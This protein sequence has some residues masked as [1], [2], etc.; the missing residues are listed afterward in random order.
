MTRYDAVVVGS[1]PN[2][3]GAAI[4]L[5]RRGH[6][7][8][9]LEGADTI[10]GGMRSTE[11]TLPGFVQDIC[12]AVHP[13]GVSSPL[14]RNL[15]LGEHG[16]DWIH[17]PAAMAH[18]FDDGTAA[19]LYR[20]IEDT[21][22][23]FPEGAAAYRSLFDPLARQWNRLAW[24]V[25]Q[26]ALHFPRHPLLMARFGLPSLRSAAGLARTFKDPRLGALFAGS[27]GHAILPLDA[28]LT[29]S[30]G[31]VLTGA[32]HGAGW[33]IPRG[34]SQRLADALASYFR[35][36]GG[37]I[38]T[39]RPVRS[40]TGLPEHRTAFVD[41]APEHLLEI[42]GDQLS[43]RYRRRLLA[44]RRAPASFKVDYA[45][46]EP[47]PWAASA[48]RE[49]GTVHLGGTL[50]EMV[51]SERAV[52]DGRVA[53]RPLV[54]TA[55]PTL[56]DATRAPEGKHTLWAYC[57]LPRGSDADRTDAI[58]R[59]IERFAPGFR[60]VVIGRTPLGPAE[61]EAH[62]PN[63]V[64]GDITGGSN[65]GMQLFFRPGYTP[66]PYDTPAEGVYLCSASTPPGG[67]VH[68]MCGYWAA[69]RALRRELR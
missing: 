64:G 56:F 18:P 37:E 30:F 20:S 42:C 4:T 43:G 25:L 35:S 11:R 8:L 51:E 39:N 36:L 26:P 49:A 44:Y 33:P 47:V 1:G 66:W 19:V 52:A 27:A 50:E 61:A 9:M 62:N 55:Q 2:G 5:A 6:S 45:L 65:G 13:L 10:G 40:L 22:A 57:H 53:D 23:Q 32:A 14:F 46:S 59:Q 60:D 67:G 68:G 21:V 12:S 17:P 48:C 34:G 15:P 41:V 63:L 7:V 54:L 29:A 28:R 3:F 24:E 31:I 16:L 38:E 69:R 58:E